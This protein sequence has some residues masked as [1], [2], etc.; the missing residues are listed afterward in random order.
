MVVGFQWQCQHEAHQIIIIIIKKKKKWMQL[1]CV[2]IDECWYLQIV[3]NA[4][5]YVF[6]FWISKEEIENFWI[7]NVLNIFTWLSPFNGLLKLTCGTPVNIL[8]VFIFSYFIFLV[9]QMLILLFFSI[10]LYDTCYANH[11]VVKVWIYFHILLGLVVLYR[12]V[13]NRPF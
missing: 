12:L 1:L 2:H 7:N 5:F 10:D 11:L 3:R 8:H 13:T 4:S 9:P 6:S